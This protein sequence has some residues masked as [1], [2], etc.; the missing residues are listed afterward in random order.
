MKKDDLVVL[1][2][3]GVAVFMIVKTQGLG[4]KTATGGTQGTKTGGGKTPTSD[5]YSPWFNWAGSTSGYSLFDGLDD[6]LGLASSPK[7]TGLGL[8]LNNDGLGMHYGG[9]KTSGGYGITGSW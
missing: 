4:L 5:Y 3:A 8:K 2:L 1:G 6:S 7:G 9:V